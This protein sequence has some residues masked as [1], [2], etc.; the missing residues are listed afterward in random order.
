MHPKIKE[1]RGAILSRQ[2]AQ[3]D[4]DIRAVCHSLAHRV[5]LAGS[6]CLGEREAKLL[7]TQFQASVDYVVKIPAASEDGRAARRAL[8]GKLIELE[9]YLSTVFRA[10]WASG[11]MT[12]WRSELDRFRH[13]LDRIHDREYT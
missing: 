9:D 7:E 2:L 13:D 12:S 8:I 3:V 11:E 1:R 4:R 6:I 10:A 5:R